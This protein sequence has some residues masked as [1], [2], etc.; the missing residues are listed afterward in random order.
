LGDKSL[1][2]RIL[3][4]VFDTYWPQFE[5]AFKA[6]LGNNEPEEEIPPRSEQDILSEILSN[7]RNLTNKV[8]TLE[9]EVNFKVP[10]MKNYKRNKNI[11]HYLESK[12]LSVAEKKEYLHIFGFSD[13]D[14]ERM[15]ESSKVKIIDRFTS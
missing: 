6:A 1:D 7:T 8:R 5:E 15:I 10:S 4:Q 11:V 3:H 13:S 9:H 14:I 2:E 12:G